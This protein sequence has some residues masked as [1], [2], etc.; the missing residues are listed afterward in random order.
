MPK[1]IGYSGV[2]LPVEESVYNDNATLMDK[3][4]TEERFR[5]GLFS[6]LTVE[7]Q[8]AIRKRVGLPLFDTRLKDVLKPRG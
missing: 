1:C 2:E 6:D 3:A 8:N 5:Q 4:A 7:Q